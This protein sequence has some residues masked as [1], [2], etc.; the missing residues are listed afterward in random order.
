MT[1]SSGRIG[2]EQEWYAV[3]GRVVDLRAEADGD[4]HI[5]LQDAAGDKP[6]IVVAEIPAKPHKNWCKR[7]KIVFSWTHTK[8]PLS[9]EIRQK[10]EDH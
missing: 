9:R 4:I 1:R 8:F 6:G 7:R 10:V 2:A 5:A 3:T